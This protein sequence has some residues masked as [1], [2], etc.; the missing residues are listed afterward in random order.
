MGRFGW[1]SWWLPVAVGLA[2]WACG[3]DDENGGGGGG[4]TSHAAGAGGSGAA[5]TGGA[6]GEGGTP[7][8]APAVYVVADLDDDDSNGQADWLDP[9]FDADDDIASFVLPAELLAEVSADHSVELSL[10][11]NAA[12]VRVWVAGAVV[13][14]NGAP[15]AT[16]TLA[17]A[18][19]GHELRIAV[20]DFRATATLLARHLAADQTEIAT[21]PVPIMGAPLITGHHLLAAERVWAVQ[22]SKNGQMLDTL[23]ATLG[24]RFTV[25]NNPDVWIQDELEWATA[26][27]PAMR[28][29][30]AMDSIRD[31]ELDAWVKAQKAPDVQPM[32]WGVHGTATTEDKFGNLEATPPHTSK[33]VSYPFGRIYY[34]ANSVIGPN[35]ILTTFLAAQA[36]Q[37]PIEIDTGWLCIGHVDELMTFIPDP[38]SSKGFK[39]LLADVDAAYAV[40]ASMSAST[41]LPLYA[42]AH[43]YATVGAIL[44]DGALKALNEDVQQD[45]LDPI[46]AQLAAELEL[47]D[48]DIVAIPSLW[49]RIPGC[50]YSSDYLEVAALIPGL[51]NLTVVNVAA[52]PLRVYVADPFLR[53]DLGDQAVDPMIAAFRA[54]VPSDYE[55]YFVDDWYTYHVNLGEVHCGT[56]V[57]RTP[58][59]EWWTKG[60]HLL[61]GG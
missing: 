61:G 20:G 21:L 58:G 26:T 7:A 2:L 49:E 25:V 32:T 46:R 3:S 45:Y 19:A 38:S 33:G 41:S 39:L 59:P 1:R 40:L 31:R 42:S 28:L 12:L 14:G 6:A 29:D 50:P 24:A 13:L 17:G 27:A 18:D 30:I 5:G 60:L 57:M 36:I 10:A 47:E 48:G 54:A 56:N 55:L 8:P 11:G 34:G 16:Y 4:G 9:F 37:A 23:Q 53:S 44:A 51:L 15:G 52:E 43:G 35:E 22:A